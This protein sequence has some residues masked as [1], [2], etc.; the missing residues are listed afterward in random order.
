MALVPPFDEHQLQTWFALPIATA[1]LDALAAARDL[2]RLEREA[3]RFM[4]PGMYM[5]P[6]ALRA[7]GIVREDDEL[8]TRALDR[9][10]VMRLDW[11]A[12]QTRAL[13]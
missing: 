8:I 7:L 10:E 1:R 2:E 11:H 9:F 13:L 3:P 5:E 12:A 4:R 6:F